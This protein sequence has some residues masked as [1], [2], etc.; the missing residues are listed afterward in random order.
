[1]EQIIHVDNSEFFRKIMR[2]FLSELGFECESFESGDDAL[3]I[4]KT[5][6]VSCVITGLELPDMKGENFI[7]ELA[8]LEKPISIIVFSSNTDENRTKFLESQGVLGIVTKTSNWK[9]ELVKFFI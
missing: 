9:E 1:M 5:G 2:T 8:A 4:I 7:K 6:R 3:D